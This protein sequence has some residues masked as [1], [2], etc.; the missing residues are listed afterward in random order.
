MRQAIGTL[1]LLVIIIGCGGPDLLPTEDYE[2]VEVIP[3]F[4]YEGSDSYLELPS[5]IGAS[6][7]RRAAMTFAALKNVEDTNWTYICATTD[8]KHKIR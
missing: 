2:K 7:R 1:A 4:F 3:L 6:N 5:V 8:G